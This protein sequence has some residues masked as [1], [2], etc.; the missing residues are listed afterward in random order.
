[1]VVAA[2]V[3]V[4]LFPLHEPG[5]DEPSHRPVG[6]RP[7]SVDPLGDLVDRQRLLGLCQFVE[8]DQVELLQPVETL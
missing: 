4:D 5:V 6:R 7:L 1:V 2:L 8:H 3:V